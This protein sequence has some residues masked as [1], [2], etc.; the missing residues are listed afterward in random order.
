MSVQELQLENLAQSHTR[1]AILGFESVL[2]KQEGA[3]FGDTVECPLKHSFT[4]GIYVREI[5]IP[6]GMYIV[7]KIHKHAHP[8]FLLKGIVDVVTESGG[9]E[10]LEGPCAMISPEGTKRALRT[11][12]DVVWITV[13][14]NPTNTQD[15]DKLE[16]IVIADSYES[17]GQFKK[18]NQSPVIK[19][20]NKLLNKLLIQ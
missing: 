14:H 10:R 11:I 13:H 15:L 20:W 19:I 2:A 8:N 3:T 7:G 12:T 9:L 17:Y 18:L 5:S 4:D 6:K 1:D 16:E